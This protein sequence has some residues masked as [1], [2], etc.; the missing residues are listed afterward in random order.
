MGEEF[1]AGYEQQLQHLAGEL[2]P[3]TPESLITTPPFQLFNIV[4]P[5]GSGRRTLIKRVWDEI[6]TTEVPRVLFTINPTDSE[7]V[8][9]RILDDSQTNRSYLDDALEQIN[10]EIAGQAKRLE[11]AGR[12]LPPEARLTLLTDLIEQHLVEDP[13]NNRNLQLLFALPQVLTLPQNLKDALARQLPRGNQTVDCRVLV[14]TAPGSPAAELS[15]LFPERTP[16]DEVKLTPLEPED[17]ETWLRTKQVPMEFSTEIY[18]RSGGLPGKLA[19]TVEMVMRERQERLLMIMAEEA[20]EGASE[21]EAKWLCAATL[22]PEINQRT[23]RIVLSEEQASATMQI[24]H[25]CDWPESGWKGTCFVAG[26]QVREALCKYMQAH[27]PKEFHDAS[28][29]AEQFARIHAAIPS[30][31]H[32]DALVRLGIFNFCNEEL[33]REVLPDMAGEVMQVVKS[34]PGYFESSGSNFKLRPEVRQAIEAYMKLASI[35]IPE[36]DRAKIAQAWENR[37]GKIMEKMAASEDKIRREGTA[38]E[39]IQTQIKQMAGGIDKELDKLNKLRRKSQMK[40]DP[41]EQSKHHEGGGGIQIWRLGLQVAGVIIIYFS[42]M[43]FSKTSLIYIAA[44]FALI[45]IG[46]FMK[47]GLLGRATAKQTAQ[48]PVLQDD[49]DRHEKNL[50]FMNIKRG[51]LESRQNLVAASIAREKSMLKEFDKQLREPYS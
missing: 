25:R 49:L 30:D 41:D 2:T 39:G 4:G 12:P 31:A 3:R 7:D 26:P 15:K 38:L 36:E 5:D 28:G 35:T 14:T 33:L 20:I 13:H 21:E 24:L 16:V 18:Q 9:E 32:R 51:Q 27:F 45:F 23:L 10:N 42:L 19:A 11:Q 50:H 40:R 46:L 47:S 6:S 22:L 17:I 48:G 43:F 1:Y 44:G 29:P 34:A 8:A 37:R